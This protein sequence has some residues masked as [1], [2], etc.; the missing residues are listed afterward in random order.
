VQI[1]DVRGSGEIADRRAQL[2]R[3]WS[4]DVPF[5]VGSGG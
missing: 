4:D 5:G 1:P 3:G 2:L